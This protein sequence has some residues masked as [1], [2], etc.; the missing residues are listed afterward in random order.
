M[1]TF[2]ILQ[3]RTIRNMPPNT[4][5]CALLRLLAIPTVQRKEEEVTSES[6]YTIDFT[7]QTLNLLHK[8]SQIAN[9]KDK[10]QKVADDRA[11]QTDLQ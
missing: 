6:H 4:V 5:Y 10:W 3:G 1:L 8:I 11:Y 9:V 7:P 2:Q